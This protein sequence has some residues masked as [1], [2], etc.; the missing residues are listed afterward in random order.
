MRESGVTDILFASVEYDL[1]SWGSSYL[2]DSAVVL[3]EIT[4][5]NT[6]CPAGLIP[7]R[8]AVC[9]APGK[10]SSGFSAR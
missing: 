6:H 9:V 10:A 8:A 5:K 4:A 2:L 1:Q 7:A 3:K